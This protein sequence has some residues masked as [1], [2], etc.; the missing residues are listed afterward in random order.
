MILALLIFSPLQPARAVVGGDP[1]ERAIGQVLVMVLAEGGGT[2][3]GVVVAP[4]SVLTAGHCVPKGKQIRVYARLPDAPPSA[5]QLLA[6]SASVVHPGYVPN[7]VGTRHRSI[8]LALILLPEALPEPFAPARLASAPAPGAGE[9]VAIAGNGLADEGVAS[10][11]GKPRSA[12]LAVVEP[13]G[14]GA[15]LLWAAPASGSGAG[16]CEGDSGGAMLA[17]TGSL[18]AIIAFAEGLGR[19]HCG[20]LTQ[21]VLVAPQRGFIDATLAKWGE[22]ARWT[23]R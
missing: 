12:S 10:S 5:P 17:T 6:P 2:C 16:A 20:K 23:D 14:R 11:S 1:A 13:F 15:I 8:D 19:A 9:S 4:R 18:I 7:A 21:G 22:T 3:S